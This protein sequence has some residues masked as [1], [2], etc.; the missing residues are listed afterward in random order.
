MF[1]FKTLFQRMLHCM[2]LNE[3]HSCSHAL[4]N[5]LDVHRCNAPT[6]IDLKVYTPRLDVHERRVNSAHKYRNVVRAWFALTWQANP[7][8]QIN[9][10]RICANWIELR[11]YC[12]PT[13]S[14]GARLIRALH[15][16][17]TD[18][19]DGA[20]GHSRHRSRPHDTEGPI[21]GIPENQSGNDLDRLCVLIEDRLILGDRLKH[22]P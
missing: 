21:A 11:E 15:A 1:A 17:P 8:K 3:Q 22:I 9:E 20:S 16:G 19:A 4:T 10:S 5:F 7:T 18:D 13:Q 6:R 12:Q 14:G 2:A